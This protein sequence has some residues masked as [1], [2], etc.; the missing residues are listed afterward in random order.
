MEWSWWKIWTGDQQIRFMAVE[1]WSKHFCWFIWPEKWNV[2]LVWDKECW[3]WIKSYKYE[4][5]PYWDFVFLHVSG[6]VT[7]DLNMLE[8]ILWDGKPKGKHKL[9]LPNCFKVGGVQRKCQVIFQFQ[10]LNYVPTSYIHL[11]SGKVHPSKIY[12]YI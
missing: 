9:Y 7:V 12:L 8:D 4:T 3:V 2:L 10:L 11:P 6:L 1:S 5:L